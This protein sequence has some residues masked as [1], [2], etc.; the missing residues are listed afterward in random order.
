[1]SL[2]LLFDAVIVEASVDEEQ[3][4]YGRVERKSDF[5]EH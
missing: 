2:E 5:H 3:Q 4:K 1:M